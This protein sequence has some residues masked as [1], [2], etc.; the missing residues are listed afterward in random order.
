MLILIFVISLVPVLLIY[1][2]LRKRKGE[3]A[4]YK[5]ICTSALTCRGTCQI[6]GIERTNKEKSIH[7]FKNSYH[8]FYDDYWN[9]I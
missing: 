7:L 2:W 6:L 8:H 4:E 1:G 5:K 3:D 9:W